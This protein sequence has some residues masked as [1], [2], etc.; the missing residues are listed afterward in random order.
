MRRMKSRAFLLII[1]SL[2]VLALLALAAGLHDVQFQPGRAF[3]R[4][5]AE[6][7]QFS[8]STLLDQISDV[9]FWKQFAFWLVLFWLVLFIASFFSPELRKRILWA[10][11]RVAVLFLTILWLIH[12]RDKLG[13]GGIMNPLGLP[14]PAGADAYADSAPPIFVAPEIS[15]AAVYLLSFAVVALT[16]GLLWFYGRRFAAPRVSEDEPA[17]LIEI[18]QAA[19]ASLDDLSAG[20]DWEDTI[21]GCYARMTE[22]VARRRGLNRQQEMTAGEFAVRLGQV[23]LPRDSVT[24][25]TRLFESARYGNRRAED[26]E[27][28]EA[29]DCLTSILRACGEAV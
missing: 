1:P 23:G 21:L 10:F 28:Q 14:E 4:A 9:P 3:G 16:L 22:V 29:A 19:R 20:R 26:R 5:E 27:K 17:R 6:T 25:L 18:A 8:I 7:L 12:N 24:R 2:A 15:P 13:L 11:V